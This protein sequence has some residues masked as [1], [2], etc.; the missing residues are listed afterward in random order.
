MH[1][2]ADSSPNLRCTSAFSTAPEPLW[3]R[4][5]SA[6][7]RICFVFNGFASF[8]FFF[9]FFFCVLILLKM[10]I[11]KGI[12]ICRPVSFYYSFVRFLYRFVLFLIS[13]RNVLCWPFFFPPSCLLFLFLFL[14]FLLLFSLSL[15]LSFLV[16][17]FVSCINE[18]Y[19]LFNW[20]VCWQYLKASNWF[21]IDQRSVWSMINRRPSGGS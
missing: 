4:S 12:V 14:I 6:L 10:D 13:R 7:F 16:S 17:N 11:F 19:N 21:R 2:Q 20:S 3:N 8:L 9:F 5:G 18:E 15:S 1:K